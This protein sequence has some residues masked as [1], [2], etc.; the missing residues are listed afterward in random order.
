MTVRPFVAAQDMDAA[1]A[2]WQAAVGDTWP[3][4]AAQ[5]QRLFADTD[6]A[7]GRAHFVVE[8]GS[9]VV[10]FVATQLPPPAPGAPLE[11]HLPAL[12]VAPPVQRQGIGAALHDHALAHLR[13]RGARRVR[14]GGGVPRLWP[15]VPTNLPA[16]LPFFRR[17]GWAFT[18]TSHDLVRDLRD[19]RAA[20]PV[21]PGDD[22]MIA[23]GTAADMPELLAFERRE[24][25]SW[26]AA[27]AHIARLGDYADFVIAR[28]AGGVIVGA[29]I[30]FTPQSHPE[31]SDVLWMRLL[32][33]DCGGV[34]AVGVAAS[35]R[36]HGIGTALVAHGSEVLRARGVGNSCV[37]WTWLLDFYGRV[38][39]R[40]WRSYAMSW[41]EW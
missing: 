13:A 16:A 20:T 1:F 25:P 33:A 17:H 2:L 30:L 14:V 5:F 35:E 37:G 40:P 41:R 9:G 28:R 6:P 24:F 32:G 27:Y 4:T 29:L 15:G 11:G 31:R 21:P 36:G 8:A 23:I 18:E 3:L 12:L 7:F 38:G 22:V 19:E 26:Q 34:G 39:Y 10:G